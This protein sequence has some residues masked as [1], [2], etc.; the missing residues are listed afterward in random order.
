MVGEPE[1]EHDVR[2]DVQAEIV[3]PLAL[4]GAAICRRIRYAGS[5]AMVR[6]CSPRP[7]SSGW[8]REA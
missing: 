8:R 1:R 4:T 7:D 5:M 6:E 2:V 3:P